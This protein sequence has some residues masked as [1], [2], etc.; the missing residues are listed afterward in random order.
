MGATVE[1]IVSLLESDRFI[2]LEGIPGV[3]KTHLFNELKDR[4]PFDKT[5]F[6]TFHPSTDYSDFVGGIKPGVTTQNK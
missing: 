4:K 6:L 5:Y 1:E 3:G 2:I